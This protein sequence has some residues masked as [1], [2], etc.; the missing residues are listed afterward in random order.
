MKQQLQIFI[1]LSDKMN[2]LKFQIKYGLLR[3]DQIREYV[4]ESFMRNVGSIFMLITE[5]FY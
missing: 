3:I 2:L 5:L 1:F 4:Y